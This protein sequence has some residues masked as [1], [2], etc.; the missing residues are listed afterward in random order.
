[1]PTLTQGIKGREFAAEYLDTSARRVDELRKAGVLPSVRD[2][3]V[4]KFRICDLD[5][6]IE[7]L[8]TSTRLPA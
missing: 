5:A 4:W 7:N 8:P 3:R 6:Y 1:M 2:G